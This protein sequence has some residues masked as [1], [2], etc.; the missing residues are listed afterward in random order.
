MLDNWRL[1]PLILTALL[2]LPP[3]CAQTDRKAPP[4]RGVDRVE[5]VEEHWPDGRLRLRR[6]VLRTADGTLLDHGTYTRW[7]D[8]G[9]QEYQ[10]TFIEGQIHGVATRWH[11]NGQIW[12]EQHF[13]HGQRHGPRYTWDEAGRKRKV[14]RR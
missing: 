7:H 2:F 12:T 4:P 9:Q 6:E 8:N 11:R 1:A 14:Q 10:A 5:T 13:A 3:G